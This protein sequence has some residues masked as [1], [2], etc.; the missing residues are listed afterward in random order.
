[1]LAKGDKRRYFEVDEESLLNF[2]NESHLIFIRLKVEK[3]AAL[4]VSFERQ[5]F[6]SYAAT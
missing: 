6:S 4:S 2:L 5:I 3:V 1:V